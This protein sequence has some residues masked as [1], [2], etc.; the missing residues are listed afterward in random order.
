MPNSTQQQ[1]EEVARLMFH[2]GIAVRMDYGHE[3]S[4]SQT[5]YAWQAFKENFKYR[6]GSYFTYKETMSDA[7][8]KFR[9]KY[10]LDLGRP[11]MYAGVSEEEGGHAFCDGY[12]DTFL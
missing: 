8:W 1:K 7:E 12:R 10:D 2:C 3:S 6:S 4:G 9:L 5:V 11:I